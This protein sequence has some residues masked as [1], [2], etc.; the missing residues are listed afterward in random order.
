MVIGAL[1]AGISPGSG[2]VVARALGGGD[3]ERV[4]RTA[5]YRLLLG[6]RIRYLRIV[7]AGISGGMAGLAAAA[8]HFRYHILRR[9]GTIGGR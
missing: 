8:G 6:L 7:L 2:S 4:R 5:T 3:K 9:R 1:S